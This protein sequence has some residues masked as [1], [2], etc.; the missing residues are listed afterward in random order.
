[1]LRFGSMLNFDTG[2]GESHHKSEA[3]YPSKNTQRRK[4]EFEFQTATR[5]IE[6]LAINKAFAF[7]ANNDNKNNNTHSH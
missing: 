5:Q 7:L 1:M 6:N 4:S 2:I 3:K